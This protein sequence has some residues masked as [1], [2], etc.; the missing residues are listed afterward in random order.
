MTRFSTLQ[1][2]GPKTERST[3]VR[4]SINDKLQRTYEDFEVE[5]DDSVV[6]INKEAR[7]QQNP[8]QPRNTWLNQKMIKSLSPTARAGIEMSQGGLFG[9]KNA[10]FLQFRDSPRKKDNFTTEKEGYKS[11]KNKTKSALENCNW[12]RRKHFK[13]DTLHK[14]EGKL[15]MNKGISNNLYDSSIVKSGSN[16]YDSIV[17][18]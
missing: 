3:R 17:Q 5:T 4:K 7:T 12:I 8:R 10:D 2:E 6:E 14:G 9:D 15:F 18:S 11:L 1:N 16:R 13:G